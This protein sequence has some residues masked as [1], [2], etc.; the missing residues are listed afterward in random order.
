MRLSALGDSAIVLT[1]AE[2]V[3]AAAIARTRRLATELERHRPAGVA[4]V[5]PAFASVTVFY[6]VTRIAGFDALCAELEKTAARCAAELSTAVPRHVEIPVCYGG[7]FGPDLADVATHAGLSAAEAV[8]VHAGAVYE[9]H[10]IGF[11]PGFA[12][13]GGLPEKL[14]TPRRA[15]PRRVVPPGSVGIGGNQTGV[16]PLA[17]PGGW[18]LIGRTPLCL[19]D[20]TRNEPALL[21]AGDRVRFCAIEPREMAGP[22]VDDA[23]APGRSDEIAAPA[24]ASSQAR[25][26]VLKAG[27]FTTV[28]DLGRPGFRAS[29]VP[30]GGAADPIA[31]RVANLLVGN[32][33]E[34]AG[35]EF[36]LVGPELRFESAA[37]VALG[38]AAFPGLPAWQPVRIPA[39]TELRLGPASR[40]CRGFLAVAGGVEVPPVLGSRSTYVR[41]GIGGRCG[42]PL[43]DGD[44]LGVAEYGRRIRGHWHIDERILPPYAHEPLV[45]IVP[46]AQSEEFDSALVTEV[47]RVT[48]HSDRMGLRLSGPPVAKRNGGGSTSSTVAAGTIQ[49][50]PDGQPIV[51]LADAQT[52]GGYPQVAHVIAVDL[53]L[54]AQL[55]PGDAV[56]FE[57]VTLAEAHRLALA[58]E[59]A[60]AVLRAGIA[61]K[62]L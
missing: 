9:V 51:L 52:I 23:N 3:D 12:Y 24:I 49:V 61:E 40:G 55:R 54:V 60:L 5:V 20:P 17:T 18:N 32:P 57:A 27:M 38:G 14:H 58:R 62:F 19:F 1:L 2:S 31:A 8:A 26:S 6:D 10:A 22:R 25:L 46:G 29:G 42:R 44:V 35:L 47:Y 50:P 48:S 30:P 11:V 33:E 56:R 16:Y 15:T 59:H 13:L 21:R 53:P 4:D 34:A 28:Q 45:R 39:G 43:R 36:T 7:E 41:G 37:L